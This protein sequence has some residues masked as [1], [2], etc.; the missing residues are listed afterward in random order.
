S[1]G[2][3]HNVG[4]DLGFGEF[5]HGAAK[6]DLFRGVVEVHFS[7]YG[8][9]TMNGNG[10]WRVNNTVKELPIA[11]GTACATRTNPCLHW[12]LPNLIRFL[13]FGLLL[14]PGLLLAQVPVVE[15]VVDSAQYGPRV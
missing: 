12:C 11:G 2:P 9:C 13:K 1:L 5:A 8:V 7:D 10:K 3:F 15:G 14:I 4:E 6:L